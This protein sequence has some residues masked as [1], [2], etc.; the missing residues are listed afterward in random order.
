M[1]WFK[2]K[3]HAIYLASFRLYLV[4]LKVIKL[5]MNYGIH[6]KEIDRNSFEMANTLIILLT[7]CH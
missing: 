1:V 5:I 7:V 6:L 3:I 2:S 4:R